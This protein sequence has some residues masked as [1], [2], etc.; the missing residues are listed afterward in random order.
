MNTAM[1][2]AMAKALRAKEAAVPKANPTTSAPNATKGFRANKNSMPG[3]GRR[4]H[5]DNDGDEKGC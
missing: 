2:Q 5:D 1:Q 4:V 3:T